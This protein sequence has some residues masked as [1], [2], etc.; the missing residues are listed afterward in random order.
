MLG[1]VQRNVLGHVTVHA[2][3]GAAAR[4]AVEQP[5]FCIFKLNKTK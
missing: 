4:V 5:I 2:Q 3:H 1:A